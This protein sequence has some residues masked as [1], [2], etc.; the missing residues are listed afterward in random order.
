MLSAYEGMAMAD[1]AGLD[2]AVLMKIVGDGAAQSRM[3][4]GVMKHAIAATS[5]RVFHKD[6]RLCLEYAKELGIPAPGAQ[7]ALDYLD[8]IVPPPEAKR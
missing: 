5:N 7:L 3:A 2:R 6:L 4:D 1:K 8:K